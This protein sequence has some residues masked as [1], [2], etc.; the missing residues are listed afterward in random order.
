[1]QWNR[2]PAAASALL[3]DSSAAVPIVIVFFFSLALG[4]ERCSEQL[5]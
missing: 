1:M 3:T 4:K 2:T 5:G